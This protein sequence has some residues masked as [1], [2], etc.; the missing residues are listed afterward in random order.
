VVELIKKARP[1]TREE[2]FEMYLS[3]ARE[4]GE[5]DLSSITLEACLA[6]RIPLEVRKAIEK[7]SQ[8]YEINLRESVLQDKTALTDSYRQGLLAQE[9]KQITSILRM[10][11]EVFPEDDEKAL[12]FARAFYY[13][14]N[15]LAFFGNANEMRMNLIDAL[16]NG[17]P[18]L[19]VNSRCLRYYY[20]HEG[21][22]QIIPHLGDFEY[23]DKLGNLVKKS[24]EETRKKLMGELEAGLTI[25]SF[26]IPVKVIMPVMDH[27]LKRPEKMNTPENYRKAEN[28]I[29][30]VIEFCDGISADY[31]L[32]ID[33]VSSLEL[34]GV[35]EESEEFKF[36]VE[37]IRYEV[38]NSKRFVISNT[39]YERLINEEIEHLDDQEGRSK[40]YRSREFVRLTTEYDIGE[41]YFHALQL[42]KLFGGSRYRG[43]FG[44]NEKYAGTLFQ[45][46]PRA[47]V[48]GNI[49]KFADGPLGYYVR[50]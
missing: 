15:H 37:S 46:P 22:Q 49:V 16:K 45:L 10:A 43:R 7:A 44:P 24:A 31:G 8:Q 29:M 11:A 17:T 18:I 35:P 30:E 2:Q 27:E 32:E 40:D 21:E 28:Y 4:A 12:S 26:G 19:S 41:M 36:A 42:G 3:I 23:Q 33:V 25:S 38:N 48:M 47:E 9:S 6:N 13:V 14:Q 20:D 50:E 39:S 1:Q 5:V 34:F